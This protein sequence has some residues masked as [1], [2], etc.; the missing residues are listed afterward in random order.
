M[1]FEEQALVGVYLI[2]RF[3][4]T[5]DRGAFSRH[6]CKEEM[7]TNGLISDFCQANLSE[8]PH[9]Y[10]LRGFHYQVPPYAEAKTLSC[11]SG[12]LYDVV[13]DLREESETFMRW[14]SVKL[15]PS[16]RISLHIPKGCAN[17][18]MTM[19]PETVVHYYCSDAYHPCAERG[20]RYN[21][22]AFNFEWPHN[23]QKVSSKDLGHPDFCDVGR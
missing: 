3:P 6:F 10:T 11:L 19:A 2:E 7:K 12:E 18:F 8:N 9:P 16:K 22:P 13:V 1:K 17:A 5:D 23:P 21:D 14:I 20:I 4:F 15:S